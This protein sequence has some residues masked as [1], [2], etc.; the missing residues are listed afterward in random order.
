MEREEKGGVGVNVDVGK[1]VGESE[2]ALVVASLTT[3]K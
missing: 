2:G 3:A 1:S